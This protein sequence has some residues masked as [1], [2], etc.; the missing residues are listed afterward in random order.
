MS[1]LPLCFTSRAMPAAEW[2]ATKAMTPEQKAFI[3][4]FCFGAVVVAVAAVFTWWIS[5]P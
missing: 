2:R 1:R 4:G 5:Q 3:E